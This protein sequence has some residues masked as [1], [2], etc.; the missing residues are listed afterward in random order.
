MKRVPRGALPLVLGTAALWLLFQAL[1]PN[2]LTALNLTNLAGQVAALGVLGTALGVVLLAGEIDLA[3][4]ATSGLCAA[5]TAVL[6]TRGW[7]AP[8]ALL[9]GTLLGAS[10]GFGQGALSAWVRIPSFVVSLG[11]LLAWQGALLLV[12]GDTGAL[13][14]RDPLLVALAGA[15]VPVVLVGPV[16]VMA[17]GFHA[18]HAGLARTALPAVLCGVALVVFAAD[19]GV[20]LG[21]LLLVAL[22]WALDVVLRRTRAG[23]HLVAVGGNAEA[24]RR[25]GIPVERVRAAAFAV[26]GALAAWSGV[27]AASRVLA[28]HQSS[29]SGDTLLNAVAAA[30]IGGTSLQGGSGSAWS[31]LLGALVV[32]TIANGLDLLAVG[33]AAKFMATGA[34]LLAAVTVDALSRR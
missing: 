26:A 13:N 9:A 4:G 20:P 1:N 22:A 27:L 19:R 18:R 15:F 3:A 10:L 6:V 31:G 12:L 28:V 24:A 17:L 32:G 14:L 33:S 16:A 30:V 11:G 25:A 8:G 5:V 29:G 21:F 23:R 2:F 7:N 34:V